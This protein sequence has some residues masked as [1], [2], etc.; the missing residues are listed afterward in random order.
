MK[1]E[2]CDFCGNEVTEEDLL[3]PGE[4][5]Y[6]IP[7]VYRE[8]KKDFITASSVED[9]CLSCARKFDEFITSLKPT[10]KS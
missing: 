7:S 8:G 2:Y 9:C 6:L 3:D 5:H 4:V 1:K 10:A